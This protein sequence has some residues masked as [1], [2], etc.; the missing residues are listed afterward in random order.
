MKLRRVGL[1]RHDVPNSK[2]A[3]S[4]LINFFSDLS[5]DELN[6]KAL[7]LFLGDGKAGCNLLW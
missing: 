6:R 3:G 2:E 5:T 1:I 7:Y 4:R